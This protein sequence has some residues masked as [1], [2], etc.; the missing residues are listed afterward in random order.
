MVFGLPPPESIIRARDERTSPTCD[1]SRRSERKLLAGRSFPPA[2]RI[3]STLRCG[4]RNSFSQE[5][6]ES[7]RYQGRSGAKRV[8]A[9]RR[10]AL[11]SRDRQPRQPATERSSSYRRVICPLRNLSGDRRRRDADPPRHD[12]DV[13]RRRAAV[14]SGVIRALHVPAHGRSG[15]RRRVGSHGTQQHRPPCRYADRHYRNRNA[16]TLG[17]RCNRNG[18]AESAC[19]RRLGNH[20]ARDGGMVFVASRCPRHLSPS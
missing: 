3:S 5:M 20:R 4:P 2:Q 18:P 15:S 12:I 11:E 19:V 9:Q 13:S 1:R 17:F 10:C 16:P 8:G 7:E 6:R 14:Q